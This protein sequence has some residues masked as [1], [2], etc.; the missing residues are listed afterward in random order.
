[1]KYLKIIGSNLKN[2][3]VYFAVT[4]LF[5][6]AI[7]QLTAGEGSKGQFLM[8]DIELLLLGFSIVMAVIQN[9]FKIKKL[10][11]AVKLLIHFLLTMAA[12]FGLFITVTGQITNVRSVVFLM[13][14]AAVVY[15]VF[16]AV[17]VIIHVFKRKREEQNKEYTPVFKDKKN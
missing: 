11:L 16:A 4:Q 7:F 17:V 6:T 2:A 14:A 3:C 12:L 5:I 8:F 15:A 1:M 9:V 10:S 13:S